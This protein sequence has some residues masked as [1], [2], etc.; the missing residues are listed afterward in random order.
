M[1]TQPVEVRRLAGVIADKIEDGTLFHAGIYPRRVLAEVIR[2][3]LR[4]E[5]AACGRAR[6]L[7]D[8]LAVC[9]SRLHAA[10]DA[11]LL[12][13]DDA[14]GWSPQTVAHYIDAVLPDFDLAAMHDGEGR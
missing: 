11:G 12:M 10:A 1:K 13:K 9:S 2:E 6:S 4:S 8:V 7:S 3:L 5:V 14:S